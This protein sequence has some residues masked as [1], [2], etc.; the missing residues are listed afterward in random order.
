MAGWG[1]IRSIPV[2]FTPS[3]RCKSRSNAPAAPDIDHSS[4]RNRIAPDAAY[5]RASG[6]DPAVQTGKFVIAALTNR[7]RNIRRSRISDSKERCSR[8]RIKRAAPASGTDR[9]IRRSGQP[10]RRRLQWRA[11]SSSQL[12]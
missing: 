10:S 3:V 8:L 7:L 6:P 5:N 9:Q 1:G 11:R 12:S 4:N 2:A